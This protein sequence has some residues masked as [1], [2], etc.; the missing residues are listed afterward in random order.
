[1]PSPSF[2]PPSNYVP[3]L[4][5]WSGSVWSYRIN[6]FSLLFWTELLKGRT[7]QLI[8]ICLCHIVLH[9]VARE[10]SNTVLKLKAEVSLF[11]DQ[12]E[13]ENKEPEIRKDK[14]QTVVRMEMCMLKLVDSAQGRWKRLEDPGTDHVREKGNKCQRTMSPHGL[15][16]CVCQSLRHILTLCD[17]LDGRPVRLPYLWDFPGKSTGVGPHF[18][19]QGIFPTQ[20]LNRQ[21]L[22]CMNHQGSPQR[23]E[24]AL[25]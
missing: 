23:T 6:I 9:I 25:N 5:H 17:S 24:Q 8:C 21:I 2:E 1:M 11:E 20:G 18:L 4:G 15:E 12:F 14:F 16:N 10:I 19:L 13:L 7:V 22:Y 3:L